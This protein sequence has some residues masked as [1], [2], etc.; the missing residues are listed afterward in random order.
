MEEEFH[1][2]RTREAWAKWFTQYNTVISDLNESRSRLVLS[3]LPADEW[4][5]QYQ[6]ISSR[7]REAYCQNEE[8]LDW[9][10][11]WFTRTPGRWTREVADPLLATLFRYIT[12]IQD[13]GAACEIAE[14]LMEF[15]L[16]QGDEVSLMK[17]YMVRTFCFDFL[18]PIHLSDEVH[19]DCV[20]ARELYERH[21]AELTPEERSM[22]LS[23][24]DI[25]F[26]R[27]T[28]QLKLGR[29]TP[30]MLE[31]MIDW[32]DAATL[33]TERVLAEDRGYEFNAV[34]PH[35]DYYL[36]LAA[37]CL[38]PG[39]CTR[40]QAE[41]IHRAA[42]RQQV[43]EEDP[44]QSPG[45]QVRSGL[46]YCMAGRL[47]GLC[48]DEEVLNAVQDC[49]DRFAQPLSSYGT[50]SQHA[51]EAV[52]SI[53][54]VTETLTQ[55]G[56]Q[57]A[58]LYD[59]VQELFIHHFTALPYTVLAD[60]VCASYNY[61]YILSSLP[62]QSGR[63]NLIQSLMKLTMFRQ[64]QTFMH[65]IMVAKLATALLDSMLQR[66]PE[67]LVG[68][69][70]ANTV[71]EVRERTEEFRRY[72]YCGALLHD[73][74]KLLCS[75]V[76]NA[77]SHRLGELEFRVLRYHPV[78]GGEMLEHL[79]ELSVFRDIA[80]GHQKSFDGTSGYPR[81]FDN[82]ASPQKVFI[83][84]IT[85][86]DSLDAA[87]DHLGRNYTTAKDFPAVMKELRAGR[88]TRYSGDVVDLLDTDSGL[89]SRIQRLLG[90]G[91]RE[92][93]YSVHQMIISESGA[94]PDVQRTHDWQ[95]DLGLPVP[96]D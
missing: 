18:E 3:D 92:V 83:D 52:E 71:E 5:E 30:E 19:R 4:I 37:L 65:S 84:I 48:S 8:M 73:V 51:V 2:F 1:G 20:L 42:K 13:L 70:G 39:D 94:H 58:E 93:Y 95:Y 29:A 56:R 90:D 88:D 67:L 28:N 87:T 11:R 41:A 23:I 31:E 60:Y 91:R 78:T 14:S 36:S 6:S 21:C 85:I 54:L 32:Y 46:V 57:R 72:L 49:M 34:L 61:C 45:Y 55:G 33:A 27:M 59:A 24:Y 53:R 66:R 26:D 75:S 96:I 10:V 12:R 22:G 81:E 44:D 62:N 89:Q 47:V 76:I 80:L 35:F 69:L 15:Y 64:V 74:G 50:Y 9:H 17:C 86:C 79:P 7:M 68:Q 38:S 43:S 16:P 63:R 77:Q 82:T 40:E 25:E